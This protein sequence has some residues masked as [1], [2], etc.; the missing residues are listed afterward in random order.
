MFKLHS[1][2]AVVL[3]WSAAAVLAFNGQ[4]VTE[5]PLT[6]AIAPIETV[7]RFEQPQTV[8]VQLTNTGTTALTVQLQV[9]GLVDE[10]RAIDERQ[11]RVEVPAGGFANSS[12]QF[13]MG[14]GSF[15]ALYPFH[16][17]ATFRHAGQEVSTHAVQIFG[18]DFS[19]AERTEQAQ[20]SPPLNVVPASSAL[21]LASLKTHRLSWQWFERPL[22]YLPVGWEGNEETSSAHF[23]RGPVA[24]GELRQALQIHPPFK[25]GPGTL[26]VEYRL[27]L[28]RATPIELQF[29]NAIRDHSEKEPPSDGVTFRVWVTSDAAS[30]LASPAQPSAAPLPALQQA[31]KVFERH[32]DS[33]RWL[34]GQADL[35][36]FAG[37]E[38]LL[39]LESHPG[40]LRNTTCDAGF[41]GDPVVVTGARPALLSPEAKSQLLARARE[42]VAAGRSTDANTFIFQLADGNRAA[43]IPGPNGVADAA[44]AF[45]TGKQVVAFEGV[46]VAV[47]DQ[48]LGSW[49]AGIVV[50]KVNAS[51]D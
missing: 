34:A 26:F 35:S 45:G 13:A 21:A 1:L 31:E 42:A 4:Q 23:S 6:V 33:K 20:S 15:S 28:P 39:R 46:N 11:R 51:R 10:C 36:K 5:G 7:T 2:I 8:Q 29:F 49:P 40:P 25:G 3:G 14:R 48:V 27:K 44:L 17:H 16:V 18:T 41:W 30:P 50:E 32:T 12:F 47:F 43:V 19:A 37:Q 22:Q 38:V 24:R 9:T